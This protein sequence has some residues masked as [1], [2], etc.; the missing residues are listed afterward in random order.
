MDE[1]EDQA[2]DGIRVFVVETCEKPV[3]LQ[4]PIITD[5]GS[6]AANRFSFAGFRF[7]SANMGEEP[8]G[9]PLSDQTQSPYC[10]IR[11][12][13]ALMFISV[14]SEVGA[15]GAPLVVLFSRQPARLASLFFKQP[16]NPHPQLHHRIPLLQRQPR[17][18][19]DEPRCST[20]GA[21]DLV[22][23]AK[24]V[25][26]SVANGALSEQAWPGRQIWTM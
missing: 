11:N 18:A 17:H 9:V 21:I 23:H 13:N 10:S 7:I 12:S 14:A 16:L 25:P 22:E 26:F 19:I 5:A 8:R 15:A 3:Y 4:R 2:A 24:A 1:V 20:S 6:T